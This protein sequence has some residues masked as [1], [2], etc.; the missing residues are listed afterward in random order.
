[1]VTD[2]ILKNAVETVQNPA[3]DGNCGFQATVFDIRMPKIFMRQRF[4]YDK[5]EYHGSHT[6]KVF[7]AFCSMCKVIFSSLLA[8]ARH[9]SKT[10]RTRRVGACS[11]HILL[12]KVKPDYLLERPKMEFPDF[13]SDP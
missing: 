12:V 3:A 4:N 8:Q 9:T 1:M 7:A 6:A 11:S 10:H 5:N 2:L 13:A